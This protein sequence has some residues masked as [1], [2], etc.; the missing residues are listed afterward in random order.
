VSWATPT[1]L[2][3]EPLDIGRAADADQD[4]VGRQARG[5]TAGG[6]VNHTLR[7][8]ALDALDAGPEPQVDAVAR[9]RAR[10]ALGGIRVFA[11]Q[12]LPLAR[13]E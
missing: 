12:D 11:G 5:D 3:A 13:E 6:H 4:G 2:E 10:D 1:T 9:Q 8:G 7:T